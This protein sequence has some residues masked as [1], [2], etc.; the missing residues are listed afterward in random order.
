MLCRVKT[1]AVY[2]EVDALG[3]ERLKAVLDVAVARVEVGISDRTVGR[4]VAV[5]VIVGFK[6]IEMPVV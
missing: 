6:I 4:F 1:E 3:K 2:A 5:V